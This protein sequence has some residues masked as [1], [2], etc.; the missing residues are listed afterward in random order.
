MCSDRTRLLTWTL[1][2][3]TLGAT[4][5]GDA[6]VALRAG[7]ESQN[8]MPADAGSEGTRSIWVSCASGEICTLAGTVISSA[9]PDARP[10]R[11]TGLYFPQDTTL[12]PDGRLYVVDWNNHRV[13]AIAASI[14]SPISFRRNGSGPTAFR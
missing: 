14:H 13:R 10:P 12:G 3:T 4:S 8:E 2:A 9:C 11:E 1:C 7:G 5:C 6:H